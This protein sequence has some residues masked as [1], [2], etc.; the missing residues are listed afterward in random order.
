MIVDRQVAGLGIER[1]GAER[2]GEPREFDE[3]FFGVAALG[4]QQVTQR[5][6][7]GIHGMQQPEAG[8]F[9]SGEIAAR[10]AGIAAEG[11]ALLVQD[12]DHLLQ[13][14]E[15]PGTGADLHHGRHESGVVGEVAGAV[16]HH[17]GDRD[18]HQVAGRL[19][20]E[21][22]AQVLAAQLHAALVDAGDLVVQDSGLGGVA[23]I[24]RLP[25][26][27]CSSGRWGGAGGCRATRRR[28]R[29]WAGSDRRWLAARGRSSHSGM[30]N[31]RPSGRMP[32]A[33]SSETE[34]L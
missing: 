21:Q 4:D 6:Q 23:G 24:A 9:A 30:L 25:R 13:Q 16:A 12:L 20:I 34:P 29:G 5:G 11:G 28:R 26:R 10:T 15:Q 17:A 18:G 1:E 19:G 2:A 31:G 8:N 14:L 7:G 22:Q 32:R 3:E 27:A 33:W